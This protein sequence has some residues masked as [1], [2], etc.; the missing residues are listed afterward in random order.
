MIWWKDKR[1]HKLATTQHDDRGTERV[2]WDA[3]GAI[4]FINV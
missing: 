1:Y 4:S 3:E 2:E